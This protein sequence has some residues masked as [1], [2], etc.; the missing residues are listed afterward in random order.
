MTLLF[1]AQ[2]SGLAAL[3]LN[4]TGLI[5]QLINFGILY[6]VLQR[7]AF[8]PILRLLD[9]RRRQIAEGLSDAAEAKQSLEQAEVKRQ[10]ILGDARK[11]ATTLVETARSEAQRE[12]NRIATEA[13]ATA[14]ATVAQAEQRIAHQRRQAQTELMEE[15]GGIVATATAA[16]TRDQLTP[17]ADA[18]V[19]ER[20]LQEAAK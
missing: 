16:V 8:P 18:A 12:A 1:A 20:A 6:Y 9:R 5:F 10:E 17:K 14:S 13:Q 15:L 19:V 2:T 4:W 3:G 11:E 7:W